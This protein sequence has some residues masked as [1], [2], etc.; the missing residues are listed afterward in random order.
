MIASDRLP[1]DVKM[2]ENFR[3]LSIENSISEWTAA[4]LSAK[5]V[6]REKGADAV[7]EAGYDIE[8]TMGQIR[9][10][11]GISALEKGN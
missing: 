8:Y 10:L 9:Q 4:I 6:E 1:V 2:T 5:S 7:K 3:F 11:Y